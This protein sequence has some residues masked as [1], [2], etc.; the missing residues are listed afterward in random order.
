MIKT[1]FKYYINAIAW[2]AV[3]LLLC[4]LQG[5]QFPSFHWD[6]SFSFDKLVHLFF[7]A[8]LSLL[9]IVARVKQYR[10][11]PK[12][13]NAIKAALVVSVLYGMLVEALQALVFFQRSA[14]WN[15]VVAN[16]AGSFIGVALFYAIYG[17]S[18][19]EKDN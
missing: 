4:A 1:F 19:I 13:F 17:K 6:F 2:G 12:R 7:Y 14:D 18:S 11:S 16:T 10:F 15:D 3:I 8:V 5:D 9:L